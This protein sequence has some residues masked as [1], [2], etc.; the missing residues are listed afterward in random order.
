M[1]QQGFQSYQLPSGPYQYGFRQD[2]PR[3]IGAGLS[4]ALYGMS[5]TPYQA[6]PPGQSKR[7]SAVQAGP[8][9]AGLDMN[10]LEENKLYVAGGALLLAGVVGLLLAKK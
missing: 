5:G 6:F 1:N 4:P 3:G 7:I 2:Y 8:V 10:W 9:V